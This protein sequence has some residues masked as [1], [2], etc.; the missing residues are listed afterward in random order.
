[1]ILLERAAEIGIS[2]TDIE[3]EKAVAA[4]KSDY[5]PG[6]FEETLLEF[7]VSYDTWESRLKTRLTMEKVIEKELENRITI[8]PEDIA[9]YYKN[10][11]QGKNSESESTPASGDINEIIVKQ[12]RRE[13]AEE[14]YKPWIEELKAKYEIEI[15]GEQWE[16]IAEKTR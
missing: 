16:I 5:P 9:E 6:E 3:L 14:S 12:L 1:M 2:V 10:N 4:I 13:K 8:T 15:N 7:A 11:F